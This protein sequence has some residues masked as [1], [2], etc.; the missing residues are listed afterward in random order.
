MIVYNVVYEEASGRVIK[1][2]TCQIETLAAQAGDGQVSM[3]LDAPFVPDPPKYILDGEITER[4][5]MPLVEEAN[6]GPLFHLTGIPVGT[7]VLFPDGEIIVDDGFIQWTSLVEGEY[8]F[9]LT[10]FPYVEEV[11]YARI[12]HA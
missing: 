12:T 1:Y 10:N 2:G 8:Q 5:T 6:D 11:R 7:K 9:I 4:P 3:K